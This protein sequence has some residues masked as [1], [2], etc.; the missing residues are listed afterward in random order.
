MTRFISILLVVLSC[1]LPDT[2]AA[3]TR[4]TQQATQG[5]SGAFP[6]RTVN[7]IP[8]PAEPAPASLTATRSGH[9]TDPRRLPPG[10]S[11]LP[12]RPWVRSVA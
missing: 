5:V 6:L 11:R 12:A 1:G 8:L 4:E 9:L 7:L 2:A 10:I 3:Q